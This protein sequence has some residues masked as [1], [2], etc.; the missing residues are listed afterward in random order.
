M[1]EVTEWDNNPR[2][3]LVWDNDDKYKIK[4]MV[5]YIVDVNENEYPIIGI[6]KD[7]SAA[8]YKHCAEIEEPKTRRMTNQEFAWWLLDGIKD[9]KHREWKF[10]N[11]DCIFNFFDYEESNANQPVLESIVIRE[12]GGEWHIPL[13]EVEE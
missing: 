9:G 5:V 10:L 2:M 8:N 3:M 1:K 6:N 12:N 13:V 11:N 7:G 4:R